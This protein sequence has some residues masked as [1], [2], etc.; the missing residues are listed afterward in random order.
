[1]HLVVFL[2]GWRGPS[3]RATG[4]VRPRTLFLGRWVRSAPDR[5]PGLCGFGGVRFSKRGP[6]IWGDSAVLAAFYARSRA[7]F[8]DQ[9]QVS[10]HALSHPRFW[11]F[12]PRFCG[13]FRAATYK[14]AAEGASRGQS[15]PSPE[16]GLTQVF[17]RFRVTAVG[18]RLPRRPNRGERPGRVVRWSR[19]DS[20][21]FPVDQ[22][23]CI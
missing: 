20:G 13:A 1:M 22:S 11:R 23:P 9:F 4:G 17:V 7:P 16:L 6:R 3:H 5:H 10:F 14:V 18:D 8:H 19:P 15:W 21:I 12:R 2:G